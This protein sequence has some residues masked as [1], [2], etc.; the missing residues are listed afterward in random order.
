MN[1]RR[2]VGT[3][4]PSQE[5]HEYISVSIY[6]TDSMTLRVLLSV[7]GA[8]SNS[9]FALVLI[10]LIAIV[11]ALDSQ[12]IRV[13]YATDLGTPG[14]IQILLFVSFVLFAF[15]ISIV[16]MRFAK[17]NDTQARS[18]RPLLFRTAYILST[19]ALR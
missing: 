7:P 8:V 1:Q 10:S 4:A 14:N 16:L 19:L 9:K 5:L 17:N 15:I 18:S 12:F 2:Y 11:T 13:F 3:L 6:F